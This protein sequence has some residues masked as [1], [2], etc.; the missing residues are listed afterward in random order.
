[1][2]RAVYYIYDGNRVIQE[3]N[4]S[5]V[6]QVTYTRGSDLSGS[7]EGAGGIGGLL[8]RTDGDGSL[9]YHA[10]GNG[11]IT[12]L[13]TSAQ[14]LGASYRYDPFGNLLTSSGSLADANTY[15]FSSKEWIPTLNSYY[16]L[17][18]FYV[19][20]LQRWLNRDPIMEPGFV[21]VSHYSRLSTLRFTPGDFNEE[22]NLFSFVGN[23]SV[24]S[25]DSVGLSILKILIGQLIP[26]WGGPESSAGGPWVPEECKVTTV[27]KADKNGKNVS[28][29]CHYEC[30]TGHMSSQFGKPYTVDVQACNLSCPPFP[31]PSSRP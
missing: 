28:I 14:G 19:P 31:P 26:R 12:Y 3:R 11:N 20:G 16:Y 27:V 2:S 13:E 29:T 24:T 17:Y 23:E 5:N 21:S 7:L 6:P 4:E 1:L 10:D 25:I 18:R 22:I 15:R 30:V 9:Y 8:A